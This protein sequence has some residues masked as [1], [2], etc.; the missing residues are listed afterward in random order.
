M[1]ANNITKQALL[2]ALLVILFFAITND[3]FLRGK[4]DDLF[5]LTASQSHFYGFLFERYMTWSGRAIIELI[6]IATI[7]NL[8]IVK[9]MIFASVLLIC[10]SSCAAFG[11]GKNLKYIVSFFTLFLL[12]EPN[13]LGNS[14]YWIV[15]YYNYL[16]P[17]SLLFYAIFVY[18]NQDK[19]G[20]FSKILS[21]LS[22]IIACNNEQSSLLVMMTI[23]SMMIFD[24]CR[25]GRLPS[26]FNLLFLLFAFMSSIFLFCAPGNYVRLDKEKLTWMANFDSLPLLAKV[27]HGIDIFNYMVLNR[28]YILIAYSL[29]CLLYI[30]KQRLNVANA[31]VILFLGSYAI[32]GL[33]DNRELLR[34][35]LQSISDKYLH[36]NKITYGGWSDVKL[37]VSYWYSLSVYSCIAITPMLTLR[38]TVNGMRFVFISFLAFI[39]VVMLSFS[40]T[41]YASG[42]RVL[43]LFNL[44]TIASMLGY[45]KF[46][47]SLL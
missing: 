32:I 4:D 3:I 34:L 45:V 42:D 24:Y 39:S 6:T 20:S 5:F 15:G 8:T 27:G 26:K 31:L 25:N 36:K 1:N 13:V 30:S 7:G 33:T 10:F 41:V 23:P 12:I 19:V 44:I 17:F 22:I 47:R 16:L 35:P 28:N 11:E 18:V 29:I 9:L 37:Y 43:F 14:V 38:S 21:I 2:F 46:E 40:P